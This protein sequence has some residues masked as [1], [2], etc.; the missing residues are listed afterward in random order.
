MSRIQGNSAV[1]LRNFSLNNGN[2]ISPG[3]GFAVSEFATGTFDKAVVDGLSVAS[4]KKRGSAGM[5]R[6][7]LSSEQTKKQKFLVNGE[8]N[9]SSKLT[10][11]KR[12]I[13]KKTKN[14]AFHNFNLLELLV[15]LQKSLTEKL[16]YISFISNEPKIEFNTYTSSQIS[17][18]V[19]PLA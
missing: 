10:A 9:S 4:R 2:D 16:K 5:V 1:L 6:L 13:K 11:S 17:V 14:L 3:E 12:V 15:T 19:D 18:I 7:G 8:R